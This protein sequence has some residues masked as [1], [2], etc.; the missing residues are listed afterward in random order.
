MKNSTSAQITFKKGVIASL[1]CLLFAVG[2]ALA[3]YAVLAPGA[4]GL[5]LLG[6]LAGVLVLT[7]GIWLIKKVHGKVEDAL[8]WL[9]SFFPI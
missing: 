8:D 2:G 9:F 3:G 1:G 5:K 6:V 7:L 4:I